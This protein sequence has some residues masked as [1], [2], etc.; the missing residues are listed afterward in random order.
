[1]SYQYMD[2]Q[3]K[4]QKCITALELINDTNQSNRTEIHLHSAADEILK[5]KVLL[6]QGIITQ[7]EFNAKKNELLG[8]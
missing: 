4:A 3:D 8:L 7:E 1:M 5:F 6:D 2:A